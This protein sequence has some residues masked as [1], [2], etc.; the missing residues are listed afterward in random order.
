MERNEFERIINQRLDSFGL[1]PSADSWTN[2]AARLKKERR[3]KFIIWFSSIATLVAILCLSGIMFFYKKINNNSTI[4]IE[5]KKSYQQINNERK[6]NYEPLVSTE[7]LKTK[8]N[9]RKTNI[10][11]QNSLITT[12]TQENN[13]AMVLPQNK[14]IVHENLFEKSISPQQKI[15]ASSLNI[16]KATIDSVDATI[17]LSNVNANHFFSQYQIETT[18]DS[19]KNKE[20]V[21]GAMDSSKLF[22]NQFYSNSNNA[23]ENKKNSLKASHPWKW[24]LQAGIGMSVIGNHFI[25]PNNMG[26][27]VL[28]A[29]APGSSGNFSSSLVLLEEADHS[30]KTSFQIGMLWQ[31]ERKKSFINVGF[32]YLNAGSKIIAGAAVDS[33]TS[34]VQLREASKAFEGFVNNASAAFSETY[35]NQMHI[36]ELQAGYGI[37]FNKWL[38]WQFNGGL[39]IVYAPKY[40]HYI[41]S[42]NIYVQDQSL[43]KPINIYFSTGPV[44]IIGKKQSLLIRPGIDLFMLPVQKIILD[45]NRKL[46]N[47]S[48]NIAVPLKK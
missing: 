24:Y 40:L 42:R 35:T 46:M 14:I 22:I 34:P 16:Q 13:L 17:D 11:Q 23:F 31:K 9:L 20:G 26:Q 43:I 44:F 18:S 25:K 28:A 15:D 2:I 39:A 5:N 29:F 12:K 3:R 33:T 36:L 8:E 30:S 7:M 37:K 48:L 32:N 10:K 1:T 27:R 4:K 21:S 47:L 45:N 6:L 41:S 19:E 38:N